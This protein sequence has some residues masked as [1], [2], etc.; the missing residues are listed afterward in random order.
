MKA[1]RRTLFIHCGLHKTG[2]TAVQEVLA[3]RTEA[4]RAHGLL[5]PLAGRVHGRA[6]HNI[7]WQLTRDGWFDP[8]YGTLD[9]IAEEIADFPGDA[10]L[11]SECF[12]TLLD[13]PDGFA[14]LLGHPL[15][16]GHHGVLL[17]YVRNQADYLESLGAELL[18]HDE[19][20]ELEALLRRVLHHRWLWLHEWSFAFDHAASYRFAAAQTETVLV[21]AHALP[22]GSA[23]ADLLARVAPNYRPDPDD[24]RL[25][26]NPRQDLAAALALFYRNRVHRPLAPPETEVV[27]HIAQAI[28]AWPHLSAPGRA[29]MARRFVPG[30]AWLCLCGRLPAKGLLRFAT[31]SAPGPTLERVFSFETQAL[32]RALSR[33]AAPPAV[34]DEWIATAFATRPAWTLAL[35]TAAAGHETTP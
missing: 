22:L 21:N 30:N 17:L 14:P 26:A 25:R 23:V 20:M 28:G 6:H 5:V 12:E 15:L 7:A 29:A 24:L 3:H 31:P 13:R 9:E 32:I 35:D 2:T 27:A 18:R 33:D 8:L 34:L 4:L 19:D 11:S 10:I 16:R 1:P